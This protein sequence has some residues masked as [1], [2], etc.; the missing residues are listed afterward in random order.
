MGALITYGSYMSR[1]HNL[2]VSALW[3]VLLDTM[4]ALL[5]GFIIFPTGFSVEGFDPSASGPGLIFHVLPQLFGTLPGGQLFGTAFFILLTIAAL[6]STVSLL[7]VPVS[8][9]IDEYGWPRKKAVILLTLGIFALSIPSALGNGAVSS[10]S[11]LP[12][13]IGGNFL[14]FMALVWNNYA[15]PIG[16]FFIAVFVAYRLG[17]DNSIAELTAENAWFPSIKLWR[18]LIR[19][20]S[21]AAILLIILWP[22]LSTFLS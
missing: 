14:G 7:E 6:T 19:F 9:C 17:L 3:V 5:A 8:H 12:Q 18:F 15:L 2:G 16:G 11:S 10:L 21:P 4:I 22:F 20:V 1:Q 13:A